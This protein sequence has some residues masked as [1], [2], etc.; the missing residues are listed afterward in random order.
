MRP[1]TKAKGPARKRL[2]RPEGTFTQHRRLAKLRE[3]L[4]GHPG[5]VELGDLA[6]M[7][8][9]TTRS[10]R[11]YLQ[12]LAVF[13]DHLE[14][15][16][17][18]PGGAHLWR[19]KPSERGRTVALRRTQAF[20]LLAA[21]GVFDVMRGSALFDEMDN[22]LRQVLMLAQRP[23]RSGV[24]GELASDHR[25]EERLVY[26]PHPPRNF[27]RRGEELDALFLA[28]AELYP[29]RFRYATAL[30]GKSAAIL[31][32]PYAMVLHRGSIHVVGLDLS[33][34]EVRVF[35]FDRMSDTT[36]DEERRFLLPAEFDITH[37]LH[38]EFGV[39]SASKKH[40]VLIEFDAR[41]AGEVRDRK[42][43][44]SQKIATAPD[45]RVRLSMSTGELEA[46]KR[47]VLGFGD[48]A[49]VIEPPELVANVAAVL[50]SAA[51]RYPQV[52]NA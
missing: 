45:G 49:R 41:V 50:R 34:R 9:V 14:S 12:E 23:V 44:P 43:H 20:G 19:I 15:V 47:W 1:F 35:A 3:V 11:R 4:E 18:T 37:H 6:V 5:G 51:D 22:A 30:E 32:H 29:L 21:R 39:G 25:L 38:G 31:A 2:G 40:R 42:V 24:K 52:R 7:L 26:L 36:P 13:T 27:V 46:V 48:A 33:A 8:H 10:V 28:V 17:T 16:E